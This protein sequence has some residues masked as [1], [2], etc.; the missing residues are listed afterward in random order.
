MLK[1]GGNNA[2]SKIVLT[3]FD[4]DNLIT[5][6]CNSSLLKKDEIPEVRVLPEWTQLKN[7]I[8]ELQFLNAHWSDISHPS[9]KLVYVGAAPGGHIVTLASMYPWFTFYLYDSEP[10]DSRLEK[11]SNVKLY[12]RF[13]NDDDI[14]Y[15]KTR[16]NDLFMIFDIRHSKYR[17]ELP[18]E[19][20]NQYLV[21]D[22]EFQKK[23]VT[24]IFPIKSLL[25][26]RFPSQSHSSHYEYL[27]GMAYRH[28]FSDKQAQDFSLVPHDHVTMRFWNPE[29]M[30]AA[31]THHNYIIRQSMFLTTNWDLPDKRFISKELGVK[32][33]YDGM[34][35]FYTICDYLQKFNPYNNIVKLNLST[36]LACLKIILENISSDSKNRLLPKAK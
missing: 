10:F 8:V 3:S 33:N 5:Y 23:C 7:L 34:L 21:E 18:D 11:M 13:F 2:S 15:W 26:V 12:Q 4:Q 19:E 27:D 24:T 30:S 35:L 14:Q 20:K 29:I 31:M 6:K 22:L 28:A 25:K 32:T 17:K 16:S 9:P 1:N 36:I